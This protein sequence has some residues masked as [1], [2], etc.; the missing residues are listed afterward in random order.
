M[1][2]ETIA[3]CALVGLGVAQMA[4][5]IFR[6][7]ALKGVAAATGASPAPK[8]F[9]A[10]KGLETFSTRFALEWNRGDGTLVTVELTPEIYTNMRGPYNR[11]NAYG[12]VLAFAPV[13]TTEPA[14]EPML[15][16]I[17]E[18]ALA[19]DAPLL[20]ELGID[21]TGRGSP[22]RIR[23]TP[24]HPERVESLPLLLEAPR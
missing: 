4:G 20:K 2:R 8:V 15:W 12:A 19:G 23:Y 3:A 14:L 22:V 11:R 10:A 24:L 9:S 13:M 18:Y 1:K 6:V 16:P 17:L 5:D 7:P 21:D